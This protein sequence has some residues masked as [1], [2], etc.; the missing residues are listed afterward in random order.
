MLFRSSPYYAPKAFWCINK[1]IKEE[2]LEVIP[3][4]VQ[5]P[6][7][8]DW[9]FQLVSKNKIDI[10]KLKLEVTTK[11]LNDDMIQSIFNFAKDEQIDESQILV[12]TLS[13]P[14]LIEYYLE[15]AEEWR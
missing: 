8:G 6:S 15:A 2:G 9:G 13:R 3:Y 14:Q 11:F 12:N 7:F 10:S 5:V 4:H 1:T